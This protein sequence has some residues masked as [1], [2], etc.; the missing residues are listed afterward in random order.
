MKPKTLR[1]AN[2]DSR[3]RIIWCDFP[4]LRGVSRVLVMAGVILLASACS[5]RTSEVTQT[6][7]SPTVVAS[8]TASA[9]ASSTQRALPPATATRQP[10]PTATE[11][12]RPAATPT[13]TRLDLSIVQT[14][15]VEVVGSSDGVSWN[16]AY[17]LV[18][19]KGRDDIWVQTSDGQ[20]LAL[21]DRLDLSWFEQRDF[22]AILAD[23]RSLVVRGRGANQERG[24]QFHLPDSADEVRV[25]DRLSPCGYLGWVKP[26]VLVCGNYL[27]STSNTVLLKSYYDPHA[28]VLHSIPDVV[29]YNGIFAVSPDRTQILILPEAASGMLLVDTRTG[30]TTT[31]LPWVIPFETRLSEN[32]ALEWNPSGVT[33]ATTQ[34]NSLTVIGPLRPEAFQES[35][36]PRRIISFP[37]TTAPWTMA[38][39]FW[40]DEGLK[41]FG[42]IRAAPNETPGDDRPFWHTIEH[43]LVDTESGE[44]IAYAM[45]KSVVMG[46]VRA[47]PDDRNWAWEEQDG[48]T[49]WVVLLD[50][51]TG[52]MSRFEDGTDVT[53]WLVLD[54]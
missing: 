13:P 45:P 28:G 21:T 26:D 19:E 51:K 7:V 4:H 33:L 29:A 36:P 38:E 41:H 5:A 48:H 50:R 32:I 54:P 9:A 25:A 18:I 46:N 20:R 22:L 23:G 2:I 39:F 11:T 15:T 53:G 8:P 42:V 27:D 1:R 37:E 6:A 14:V 35:D 30:V 52:Q 34:P 31:V 40:H 12:A 3:A 49:H 47:S 43:W 17:G 10:A 16:A 24:I 44:A